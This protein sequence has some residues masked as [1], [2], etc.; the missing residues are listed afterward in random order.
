MA[1][2]QRRTALLYDA[3]LSTPEDVALVK[4]MLLFFDDIAVFSTPAHP[5]R[6]PPLDLHLSAPLVE[7]RLLQY[8][9]PRDVT[10]SHT[11]VIVRAT[12]HRAAMENAERWLAAA[13][14]PRSS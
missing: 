6:P 8:V 7:R 12:L 13:S 10:R 1:R 2:R 4:G 11:E 3:P 9:A 5:S 14:A